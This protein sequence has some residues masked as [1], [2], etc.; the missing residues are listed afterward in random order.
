MM[1]FKSLIIFSVLLISCFGAVSK[2]RSDVH[3]IQLCV[4]SPTKLAYQIV[5]TEQ[6]KLMSTLSKTIAWPNGGNVNSDE[7]KCIYV[8]DLIANG[9]GGY[10]TVTSGGVGQK[11]VTILL[12]SQWMKGMSFRISI[13]T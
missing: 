5:V 10:P 13:Y 1:G 7:I 3:N 9:N 6:G 12:Q 11:S 8:E 4:E 2:Q